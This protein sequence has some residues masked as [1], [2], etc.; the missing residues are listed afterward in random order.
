MD[1]TLEVA[2]SFTL[3]KL[4]GRNQSCIADWFRLKLAAIRELSDQRSIGGLGECVLKIFIQIRGKPQGPC[5]VEEVRS[6][7]ANG[8]LTAS[9]LG[10][11]EG[12][13]DWRPLST[14]PELNLDSTP[15]AETP[16]E[17]ESAA[18]VEEPPPE[19]PFEP[20][21]PRRPLPIKAILLGI[22]AVALIGIAAYWA[23]SLVRNLKTRAPMMAQKI[24]DSLTR[25]KPAG[26]TNAALTNVN[27]PNKTAVEPARTTNLA[28]TTTGPGSAS[29]TLA[30][31]RMAAAM[32]DSGVIP[33]PDVPSDPV[34]AT[35]KLRPVVKKTAP[36]QRYIAS[37]EVDPKLTPFGNYDVAMIQTIQRKW[38]QILN[39]QELVQGRTGKVILEF[40]LN[41][42]GLVSDMRVSENSGDEILAIL[43]QKAVREAS[44]FKAWP[45]DLRRLV[46]G[47]LRLMKFT[48]HY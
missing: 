26:Q 46:A 11:Y 8:W 40:R 5:P 38:L 13:S 33:E 3:S 27:Q 14:M 17:V 4:V 20:S 48:F 47:D 28:T 32:L 6:L 22:G 9:D 23:P 43:C 7:L 29:E 19:V 37:A 24:R 34:L 35:E 39:E 18:A 1:R 12:Q 25:D 44:P 45:S 2:G 30:S 31:N 16:I 15:P 41:S 42:M 21:T 36:V 10:Q